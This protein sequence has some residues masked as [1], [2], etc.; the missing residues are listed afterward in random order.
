M[1][2]QRVVLVTGFEPFGGRAVNTSELAVRALHGRVIAGARVETAIL[3]V[4]FGEAAEALLDAVRATGARLI[5]AVGEAGGRA[6]IAIERAA[7]NL[8]DARLPDNAGAQPSGVPIVAGGPLAYAST[9]P[10]EA[11]VEALLA[12]GLP[13]ASSESAGTF[14]CN[15]AFYA[16]MHA[17]AGHRGARGGF[18]HVPALPEAEDDAARLSLG[19]VVEA[20]EVVIATCADDP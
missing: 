12:R 10:V 4:R 16:L 1:S 13:A 11:L 6:A 15:H 19:R 8:D 14:V 17:L 20:L 18:V 2:E 5:V 3:P 9:L 7:I